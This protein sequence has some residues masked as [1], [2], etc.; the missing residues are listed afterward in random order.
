M[1]SL[2][3]LFFGA[4]FT[5][6]PG[7]KRKERAVLPIALLTL[8]LAA[9]ASI[10]EYNGW[11]FSWEANWLQA[12]EQ[13]SM[14]VFDKNY[15]LPFITIICIASFGLLLLFKSDERIGG[16]VLGL[17]LFSLCGAVLLTS[18]TNLVMLF[19]GIEIL[20]IPLFVL[21]GSRKNSL[22]SNE[23]A[24]KYFLMGAFST[25]IFLLGCALVYGST[26]ALNIFDI[27]SA[28]TKGIH[29]GI[30]KMME[31]GILF[32]L[33][34]LLFKVS[35]VPFHFWSP[36]VYEGSPNRSTAFMAMVVK[37]SAFIALFRFLYLAVSP[38]Y[39]FW[40]P[41]LAVVSAVT[42][43]LGNLTALNQKSFKRTLAYSSIAH[44][45]YLLMA[46]I[47]FGPE[48][49]NGIFFYMVA[50]ALSTVT[51]FGILDLFSKGDDSSFDNFKGLAKKHP[52]VGF[53][54]A[55]STL[56][57]AGIPATAGFVGK[58]YLFATAFEPF[59]WLVII[60]LIGSAI[61]IGYYF[62]IIKQ[63]FFDNS[64]SETVENNQVSFSQKSVLLVFAVLTLLFGL[65]PYLLKSWFGFNP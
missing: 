25:G 8:L 49:L 4:I 10:L 23:A 53:A 38:V 29:Y 57:L 1:K 47:S 13:S 59:P 64:V 56:S 21:A 45:G 65:M 50:Y 18:F 17:M 40:A 58:Y 42:I 35:A 15:S 12:E 26:G 43:L 32:L 52:L 9:L 16:D 31:I 34:G 5:L 14:F 20:S 19:L 46:S 24:F 22:A 28:S 48:G 44:A 60:A 2:V 37:I 63:A 39:Y 3:I 7:I 41:V 51:L 6:F 62:K 33:S 61:S 30:P 54:L 11:Y 55:V 36:D 27:H